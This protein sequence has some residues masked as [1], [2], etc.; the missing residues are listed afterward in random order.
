MGCSKVPDIH[1]VGLMED[2]ATL[3]ISSQHVANWLHHGVVTHARVMGDPGAHGPLGRCPE[4][5]GSCLYKNGPRHGRELRIPSCK[6][7]YFRGSKPAER[8]H[9]AHPARLAETGQEKNE[10]LEYPRS[11]DRSHRGSLTGAPKMKRQPPLCSG[12]PLPGDNRG[13]GTLWIRNTNRFCPSPWHDK[14]PHL[15]P[16]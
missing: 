4:C 6:R 10:E 2:R 8:L 12:V 3:R 11:G 14:G 15:R 7:T 16:R 1:G 5:G 13:E 9:R